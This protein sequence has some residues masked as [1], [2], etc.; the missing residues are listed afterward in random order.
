[1]KDTDKVLVLD[2]QT[3]AHLSIGDAA[4]GFMDRE[5]DSRRSSLGVF[6]GWSGGRQGW[7]VRWAVSGVLAD[8]RASL[9]SE[10][11][12]CHHLPGQLRL[13]RR[14]GAVEG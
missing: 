10:G 9:S 7:R 8:Q 5:R 6:R 3:H 4:M 11:R 12:E 14:A 13:G 2:G 1:M